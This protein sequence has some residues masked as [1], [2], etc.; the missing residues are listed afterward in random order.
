MAGLRKSRTEVREGSSRVPHRSVQKFQSD[1]MG[2]APLLRRRVME[3]D[4]AERLPDALGSCETEKLGAEDFQAI[5]DV[6]RMLRRWQQD[7]KDEQ[8]DA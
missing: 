3:L 7:K 1:N 4:G 8:G 2:E 5:V 6:F